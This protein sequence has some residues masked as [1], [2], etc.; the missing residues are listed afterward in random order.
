M[1]GRAIVLLLLIAILSVGGIIWFDYLNVI[2]AKD[3]LS[4]VYKYIPFIPGEGR[5]QPKI[6]AD[7]LL[8][9]D[10]ERLAIRLERIELRDMELD[11]RQGEIDSHFGEIAQMAQEIEQRQKRLEEWEKTLIA[12]VEDTENRDRNI[13]QNARYLN[14]MPPEDA[15]GIIEQMDDQLAIDVI[16]KTEEIAQAEGRTSIVSVWFSRMDPAR[17]A[18]LQRKMAA[19]PAGF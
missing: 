5:T 9:L 11:V 19:R 14:N 8:N 6:Q 2:D 15:V 12:T 18:E 1:I 4:P 17:A 3:L 7:D 10:A 16:R 13:E